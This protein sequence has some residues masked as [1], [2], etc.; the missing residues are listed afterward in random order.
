MDVHLKFNLCSVEVTVKMSHFNINENSFNFKT[1][2][3]AV[4]D[5]IMTMSSE[6]LACSSALTAWWPG[7][8]LAGKAVDFQMDA[9]WTRLNLRSLSGA[10]GNCTGTGAV[11]PAGAA[12][13][14]V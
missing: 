11:R 10:I 12:H 3:L 2:H 6:V 8:T 1:L 4:S 9:Y 5:G 13:A 14:L 7:R